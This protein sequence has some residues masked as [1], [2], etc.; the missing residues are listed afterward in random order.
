[1]ENQNSGENK[2]KEYAYLKRLTIGSLFRL[3]KIKDSTTNLAQNYMFNSIINKIAIKTSDTTY[4]IIYT[5]E[6]HNIDPTLCYTVEVI[7][8]TEI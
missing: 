1:M 3:K 4:R 7:Y 6:N 2:K 8:E 5:K